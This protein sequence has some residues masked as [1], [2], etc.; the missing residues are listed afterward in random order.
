MSNQYSWT[1]R[2]ESYRYS[3][4]ERM[5]TYKFE[6]ELEPSFDK[7]V[8][9]LDQKS[10]VLG[11]YDI[12]KEPWRFAAV[13]S[14]SRKY[15]FKVTEKETENMVEYTISKQKLSKQNLR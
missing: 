13:Q 6:K 2:L 14:M 8:N 4:D 9:M 10:M 1:K 3:Q 11:P 7:F 5:L 12:S 15:S